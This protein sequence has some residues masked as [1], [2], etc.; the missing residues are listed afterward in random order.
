[1]KFFFFFVLLFIFPASPSLAEPQL[2]DI[3]KTYVS[4]FAHLLSPEQINQLETQLSEIEKSGSNQVLVVTIPDLQ[5]VPIE[6][7]AIRLAEKWKPGQKE[8]NNG[9]IL[10][11]APKDRAMRIEVGYGL[12]GVLTDALSKNIIETRIVPAFRQGDYF[13]GIQGGVQAIAQAIAGEYQPLPVQSRSQD[14][15]FPLWA[16]ILFIFIFLMLSRALRR[17]SSYG[18][19]RGTWGPGLGGWSSGSSSWGG[20]S[21]GGWSSGGGFSSGGGS[22]GGGGASG[23]W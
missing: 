8:R 16:I 17:A 21:G 2:P 22:F 3:P 7:Y 23:R 4:D 12:E 19:R 14:E 13:A 20:S 15:G 9:V 6:D 5:D 10:L 18:I 11:I 1:M